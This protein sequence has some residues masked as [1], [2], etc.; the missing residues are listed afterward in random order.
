MKEPYCSEG[1]DVYLIAFFFQA[2]ITRTTDKLAQ[3]RKNTWSM[4]FF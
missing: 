2:I 3:K 4:M 1:T